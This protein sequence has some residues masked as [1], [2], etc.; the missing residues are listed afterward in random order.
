MRPITLVMLAAAVSVW[1]SYAHAQQRDPSFDRAI[2]RWLEKKPDEARREVETR[3]RRPADVAGR[4]DHRN[5]ALRNLGARIHFARYERLRGYTGSVREA[6]NALDAAKAFAAAAVWESPYELE[7]WRDF[8]RI[9]A[10]D[11]SSATMDIERFMERF[12]AAPF[13][14][15]V[16]GHKQVLTRDPELRRIASAVAREQ[17]GDLV[18]AEQLLEAWVFE[19]KPQPRCAATVVLAE[20]HMEADRF[21]IAQAL[22][23]DR[24]GVCG[25]AVAEVCATKVARIQ[26]LSP[27]RT[28]E[29]T[30][31]D[32]AAM[33]F[34]S[35]GRRAS[36]HLD[37]RSSISGAEEHPLDIA[38]RLLRDPARIE[39][40]H[41][42]WETAGTDTEL[43][44]RYDQVLAVVRS[45]PGGGNVPEV[46]RAQAYRDIELGKFERARKD[47]EALLNRSAGDADAELLVATL[48]LD[49][50]AQMPRPLDAATRLNNA[51]S[52]DPYLVAC[53]D[54]KELERCHLRRRGCAPP[55]IVCSD[56][57]EFV[58]DAWI[59]GIA[60]RPK[61][62]RGTNAASRQLRRGV[63]LNDRMIRDT[64]TRLLAEIQSREAG[65]TRRIAAVEQRVD[66]IVDVHLVKIAED[67]RRVARDQNDFEERM[68]TQ[69]AKF[70]RDVQIR[71]EHAA[72][73]AARNE[74]AAL[75]RHREL[76]RL[77]TQHKADIAML[78]VVLPELPGLCDAHPQRSEAAIAKLAAA[79]RELERPQLSRDF[80]ILVNWSK[81]PW[82]QR[83]KALSSVLDEL[84]KIGLALMLPGK[85]KLLAAVPV[86]KAFS[87][88][89]VD[90]REQK[91]RRAEEKRL[92]AR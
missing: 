27:Y 59:A 73:M 18:L 76:A 54:E 72:A 38:N 64:E 32:R 15:E 92:R 57:S 79:V 31:D 60:E 35:S 63:E 80:K 41:L 22:L 3:V 50:D 43:Q 66:V 90:W 5:A 74:K 47:L 87:E 34:D 7:Y 39:D 65:L 8:I 85:Q 17:R 11:P 81:H 36:A 24:A 52:V 67:I 49:S 91:K 44:K 62:L 26:A 4:G 58:F 14:F 56:A 46:M 33:T 30:Q 28:Y 48:L 1:S 86:L 83:L 45:R 69:A 21:A 89:I 25:D 2:T 53:V 61:A 82:D 29:R 20:L 6:F 77:W 42:L 71:F 68:T 51:R 9:V 13:A 55:S 88:Q 16:E 75:G 19:E 78:K 10:F 40:W 70:R 84:E 37:V 12:N 23:E